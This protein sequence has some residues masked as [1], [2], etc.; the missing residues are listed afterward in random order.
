MPFSLSFILLFE[1]FLM[2]KLFIGMSLLMHATSVAIILMAGEGGFW[3]AIGIMA[4]ALI[5]SACIRKR[6]AGEASERSRTYAKA[7][8]VYATFYLALGAG[9]YA[10]LFSQDMAWGYFFLPLGWVLLYI[11]QLS[12]ARYELKWAKSMEELEAKWA[13]EDAAYEASEQANNS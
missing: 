6:A 3:I 11:M 7:E 5:A 10:N 2:S 9:W 4:A 8:M 13:A 1:R 12:R